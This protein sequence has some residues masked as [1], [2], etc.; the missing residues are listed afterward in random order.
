MELDT[1]LSLLLV[2]VFSCSCLPLFPSQNSVRTGESITG[3][4]KLVSAGGSFALG[5][6][7]PSNST[8][9]YLGI[10]YNTI[11]EQTVVW[12][13]N[14]ESPIPQN[15][16]AV[17][18]IG[19]DGK[20]IWSSNVSSTTRLASNSS[21]GALLDTG[22]LVLIY[23]Y[24][25][26]P[27]RLR[28]VLN[29][30]GYLQVMVWNRDGSNKW[31]VEFQ[32]PQVKC[33]LYAHCGPFGSCGIRS[34]GLCRCLTGFEPK[35]WKDWANGRWNEGCVRKIALGCDRGDS[36]LKHENMKLP[37][38]AI[39]LGNMSSK[40][41]ETRC[42]RNCSCSAYASSKNTCFIWL[43]DLL[44]LVDDLTSSRDLYVRVHGSELNRMNRTSSLVSSV[45]SGSL[46][47]KEDMKLVRYSLQSI[48]DATNNFHEDNKL[49]EGGFGPCIRWFRHGKSGKKEKCGS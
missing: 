22:N 45:P 35:F 40:E 10:W 6:F 20:L 12:V 27:L 15:S 36:F 34:S 11:R 30:S 19:D 14:R 17:F 18:T 46:V 4:Q 16:T 21:V 23:A 28:V 26:S 33:E 37:D 1:V 47:G 7:T 13:G 32:A 41:C 48:R 25:K 3:N 31:T 8:F 2:L 42:I 49:G 43:G 38:H 5:F 44:D 39:F 29:P 9:S 24:Y